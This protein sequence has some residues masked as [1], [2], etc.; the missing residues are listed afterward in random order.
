MQNNNLELWEKVETTQKEIIKEIEQEDGTKLKTVP[1]INRLK[2]GTEIF[3]LYGR[4]WGLR[5]IDHSDMKISNSLVIGIIE[6]EFY[7]NSHPYQTSFKITN[8]TAIVS[9]QKKEFKVNT[10]YRKS[11]ET[12]TINKALSRLG[13]NADIY[14]D[15][16]LASS[17][18]V[19][20]DEL[21]S[22]DFVDIGEQ[23]D[24]H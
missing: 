24:V 2:R 8:S 9:I 3:G 14:T 6:A 5:N 20:Q 23:E 12:D 10:T 1:S 4:D 13:F 15:E 18:A 16:A 19:L 7:V 22:V 21:L 11:L 17:E